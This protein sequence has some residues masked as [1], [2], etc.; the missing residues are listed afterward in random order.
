MAVPILQTATIVCG[1]IEVLKSGDAHELMHVRRF[2]HAMFDDLPGGINL[3]A[4][5]ADR[6]LQQTYRS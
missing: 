4:Q 1:A 6:M 2:P 3:A 5:L